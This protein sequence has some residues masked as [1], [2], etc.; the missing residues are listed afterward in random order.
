MPKNLKRGRPKHALTVWRKD[1]HIEEWGWS[2]V[3]GTRMREYHDS[4]ESTQAEG[5]EHLKAVDDQP[6]TGRTDQ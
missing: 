2:C 4:Q 3:C 1:L 6:S 5:R